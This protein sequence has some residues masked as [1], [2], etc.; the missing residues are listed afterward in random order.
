MGEPQG[1]QAGSLE[2]G[3]AQLSSSF[4]ELGGGT[5]CAWGMRTKEDVVPPGS[6]H[7]GGGRWQ[8]GNCPGMRQPEE[9]KTGR[10]SVFGA[11]DG[12]RCPAPPKEL[13]TLWS[14]PRDSG[15]WGSGRRNWLTPKGGLGGPT[16]ASLQKEQLDARVMEWEGGMP[17][18]SGM[19][20]KGTESSG[21]AEG[22]GR[23]LRF[24]RGALGGLRFGLG[25]RDEEGRERRKVRGDAAQNE[26]RQGSRNLRVRY[27]LRG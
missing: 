11:G 13:P 4:R 23:G 8:V 6:Q 2:G 26:G 12:S 15:S 21:V 25:V 10:A 22:V 17:W 14:E 3:C 19:D 24:G 27:E 5:G 20:W 16:Q 7:R 9:G 18:G 1:A